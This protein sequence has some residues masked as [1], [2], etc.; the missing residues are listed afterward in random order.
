MTFS[1]VAEGTTPITHQWLHIGVPLAGETNT[2]LTLT[3]VG[4][5]N[6][7]VYT[8]E[9]ANTSGTVVSA[10]AT[11]TVILRPVIT[12]Q[13]ANVTGVAGGSVTFNVGVTGTLPLS[14]QWR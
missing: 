8:I 10:S 1:L 3:N 12:Q 5:A 2:T 14:F 9:V 6:V 4:A 7:G 13:P 11:L